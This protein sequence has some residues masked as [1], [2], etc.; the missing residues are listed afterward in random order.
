MKQ[1]NLTITDED[2]ELLVVEAAKQQ[3]VKKKVVRVSA[4]L[5]DLAKPVIAN[6][7][8]SSPTATPTNDSKPDEEQ[9]PDP[10]AELDI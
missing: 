9:G 2:Y 10:F 3:V 4:L 5:Y 1:V 6:L 7:N 8:G